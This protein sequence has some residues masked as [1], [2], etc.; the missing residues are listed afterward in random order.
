MDKKVINYIKEQKILAA[1]D[2]VLIGVS[3]GADSLALLYFLEK[4]ASDF[5]ISIGVAHLHHGLRGAAADGDEDFVR[6]FSQTAGI[7]F[8]SRKRDIR[9]ISAEEK[10]SIEE[11]GRNERYDFFQQIANENGY[12]RIAMGHH[13]NDQAETLLMR[14]IRGTGIKG[15]SG[16]KSVRDGLFIRPFL[17]LEKK[18]IIDYCE[19]NHLDYRTDATNFQKDFTRNKIRL[20]IMPMI[21]EINPKA[22]VHFNEFTKIALEY[23]AFFED[24][25]NG[26]QMRLLS[27]DGKTV[28]IDR[29]QWLLEKPVVQKE[30]LRCAI[31]KFKGSLMEIEYNHITAFYGLLKSDKTIWELHL[32]ND[33]RL[34]RRYERVM[35]EKKEEKIQK[36][37]API[38]ILINKTWLFAAQRLILEAKVINQQ[39]FEKISCFFSKEI[40]NHSEK[41]FDYDKIG[42]VLNLRSRKPG[43]FFHPVG[44]SGKKMIKKY[45]ID[46][47]ID[48]NL[49]DEI[50]L[51]AMNSEILWIVGYGINERLLADSDTKNILKVKVTLC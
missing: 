23:E 51:I 49:R 31:Y 46:K 10:I 2:H 47:K 4:Y 22:E 35:V 27:M 48:R 34:S 14:L 20:D 3:G 39:E 32:P 37:I 19:K 41:Y 9:K 29:D 12:N 24:Y 26:V 11:A 43:D 45:F 17:C 6:T 8:F 1:G 13:I 33:I 5:G 28:L 42:C 30:I 15:V 50:P 36:S 21:R 7:S 25:V 38:E 18:E 16:I 44:V 40:E